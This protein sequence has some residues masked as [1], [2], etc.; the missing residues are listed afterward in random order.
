MMINFNQMN[1][2]WLQRRIGKQHDVCRAVGLNKFS[3]LTIL[4]ATA[5]L[6][7]DAFIFAKLGAHVTMLERHPT[8]IEHIKTALN[9]LEDTALKQLLCFTPAD[10]IEH[11]QSLETKYD[12]IYLDPMFAD[13]DKR[14]KVKK[15]MQYL[16][17]IVGENPDADQLLAAALPHAN[18][19]IVVKRHKLSPLLNQQQPHHQIIGKSTR[20]DVYLPV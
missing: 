8:L 6:A 7:R 13:K 10:A 19:R 20:Y 2:D 17:E 15:D 11:L 4:D 12:V 1:L 3:N 18:K 9:E 5:G 14:A 16:Q